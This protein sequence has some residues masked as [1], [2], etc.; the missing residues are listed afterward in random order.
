MLE[1]MESRKRKLLSV[2]RSC[3][4][5]EAVRVSVLDDGTLL[6]RYAR[7]SGPGKCVKLAL[8]DYLDEHP[9]DWNVKLV[10][11][12]SQYDL[13]CEYSEEESLVFQ[14]TP[15]PRSKVVRKAPRSH[16]NPTFH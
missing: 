10:W 6:I 5:V 2:V 15:T 1:L 13:L 11:K 7:R 9:V 8:S 3:K 4:G 16:P 12:P 14:Y